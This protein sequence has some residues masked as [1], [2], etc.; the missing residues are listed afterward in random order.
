M[1]VPFTSVDESHR[2]ISTQR[3]SGVSVIVPVYNSELSLEVLVTRLY[4]VLSSLTSDF[5]LILVNDGSLDGSWEVVSRLVTANPWIRGINLMRNYGQHSALLC[6]IRAATH[7]FL[8][9]MDDDLQNPPEE[10]PRLLAKL[11]DGFDVVYGTPAQQQHGNLRNLAS[12]VTKLALQSAMGIDAA[13]KVSAF[14]AFRLDLR[15]A[16]AHYNTA[17]VSIDVLLTW[18]TRRFAAIEVAHDPRTIGKSNYSL[19][20]LFRH[21]FDMMTG[22]STLPLRI[23]T[24]IGFAFALFGL[25]ILAFVVGRFLL[26]GTTVPGF[27]FLASIVSIFAGAQLCALGIIGEYLARMHFRTM[28]IPSAVIRD[29]V[30]RMRSVAAS[31]TG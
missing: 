17:F 12:T 7:P 10:I 5:E 18:G 11:E 9:T 26:T 23:A 31:Q 6:G 19:K 14:R 24:F 13:R 22:F 29:E 21:A 4:P 15:R 8:I 28:G 20:K 30:G 1:A 16:F 25:A 2:V 3:V 27:S